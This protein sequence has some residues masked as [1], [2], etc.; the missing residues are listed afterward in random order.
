MKVLIIEDTKVKL[1]KIKKIIT[2][3]ISYA[4]ITAIDNRSDFTRLLQKNKYD[5][6]VAD[7]IVKKFSKSAETI[8]ITENLIFE[9]RD[10]E[11]INF[12]TPVVAITEYAKNA[13]ECIHDL[14]KVDITILTYSPNNED[15]I[16]PFKIKITN[17]APNKNFNFII[18]CALE[19]EANAYIDLSYDVGDLK[20]IKNINYRDISI[21]GMPGA[22][23]I[24]P[25]MGLVNAS[26]TCTQ[27]I[28]M[29]T[30]EIVCMSG[31]CAGIDG[32]AD[33]YD[34]VIPEICH[35]HDAGKWTNEGFISEPYSVQLTPAVSAKIREIISK[36]D[37]IP[38]LKLN[39]SLNK[40]EYPEDSN[41]F[42]FKVIK[43]PT[44]SGSAVIADEKT[45]EL[46]KAQHKRMTAF[47]ME[48]YALYESARNSSISPMFFSAKCVV[49]NGD[50]K[51][52]DEF[53]RVACLL[54]ARTV[55][56]ILRRGLR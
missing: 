3:V 19:K 21:E 25:R 30:P 6:V 31:I 55:Y 28:E 8:D 23:I 47:E 20:T 26:I 14:N 51:K 49:D 38:S 16:D 40:N 44:S 29:F 17:T 46:V 45:L 24:I 48:S 1:D 2:D 13:I 5:L 41:E 12:N 22:I 15:W 34:V 10:I 39:I 33:I 4:E 53:H 35:Q 43:A 56:E 52:S 42:K 27:A 50:S 9:I 18:F 7:L 36:S 32:R 11:C 37:F 54:S